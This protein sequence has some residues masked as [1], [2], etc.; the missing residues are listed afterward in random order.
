[1]AFNLS[2]V[3]RSRAIAAPRIVVYGTDGIGKSSFAAAAPKPVF[4][5]TEDSIGTLDVEHFPIARTR[6][7]VLDAL[8][9]LYNEQHDY[10]TVVLDTADWCEALI[11]SNLRDSHDAKELAYGKSAVLMAEAWREMLAWFDALRNEKGMCVV[12]LAHCEIKRFDSPDCDPYDRYQLKL[13]PRAGD[14]LREWSDAV[15]FANYQTVIKKADVGFNKE[16]KRGVT[17]GDRMLF[18]TECPAYR[19]KNRYGLPPTLPLSWDALMQAIVQGDPRN[20]RIE[21]AA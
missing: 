17:N 8:T 1:M 2:S 3:S 15:L 6:Q 20:Q 9:A 5:F 12:I 7:D 4:V 10:Q 13:S 19:A 21:Q 14:V 16:V 18:T 11:D